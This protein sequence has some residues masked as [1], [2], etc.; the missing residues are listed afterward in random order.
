MDEL[1]WS[2]ARTSGIISLSL[3]T[4]SV[5]L[6]ILNRS[7]RPLGKLSRYTLSLMH[8]SF[9]LLALLFVG[10]HV[11]SLLADSYAK[12]HVIDLFVPF[13]GETKPFWQGLGTVA[14]L[15]MLLITITG[16]LRQKISQGVFNGIHL[17]SYLLWPISVAHGLGN[18]TDATSLWYQGATIVS[19]VLFLAAIIW[20]ITS[21][22]HDH[23]AAR[24]QAREGVKQ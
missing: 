15:L 16:L 23:A 21:N 20:R 12:M 10:L 8:R 5:L 19:I 22:Y 17:S 7:G 18:G 14:L 24:R 9:S 11:L 3:L 2:I 6:G 13:L 1:F 4:G